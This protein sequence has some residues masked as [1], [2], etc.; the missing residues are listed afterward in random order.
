MSELPTDRNVLLE[1]KPLEDLIEEPLEPKDDESTTTLEAYPEEPLPEEE[2]E[3]KIFK[4]KKLF[5]I[6]LSPGESHVECQ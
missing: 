1:I 5:R 6:G 2:P 3:E 4:K